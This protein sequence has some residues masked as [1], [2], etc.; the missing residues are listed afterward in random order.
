LKATS[1]RQEVLTKLHVLT[2][3]NS[4]NVYFSSLS[5]CKGKSIYRNIILCD[6]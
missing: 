2:S 3:Q 5:Q 6:P 1:K 4:C